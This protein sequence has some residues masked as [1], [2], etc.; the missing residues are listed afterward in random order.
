MN[1]LCDTQF[2]IEIVEE[3]LKLMI[4]KN[5]TTNIFKIVENRLV[6]QSVTK[7]KQWMKL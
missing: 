6:N 3:L 5:Y 1:G 2:I 7:L 4:M